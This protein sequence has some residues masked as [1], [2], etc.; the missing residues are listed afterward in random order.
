[1][2]F[3][4]LYTFSGNGSNGI[5]GGSGVALLI[6]QPQGAVSAGVECSASWLSADYAGSGKE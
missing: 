2:Y 6:L 4:S 3:F 1:M 5:F